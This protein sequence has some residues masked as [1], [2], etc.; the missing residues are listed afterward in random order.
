MKKSSP[1]DQRHILDRL[2][3]GAIFADRD[4]AM[5]A[6]HLHIQLRIGHRHPQLQSQGRFADL[7]VALGLWPGADPDAVFD[8]DRDPPPPPVD[9][10]DYRRDRKRLR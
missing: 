1:S 4:A 6:D 9:L 5:A 2:L 7:M 10:D 3:A 8:P